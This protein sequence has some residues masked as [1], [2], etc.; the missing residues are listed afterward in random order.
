MSRSVM[1]TF[2][3]VIL[4]QAQSAVRAGVISG[5]LADS[6]YDHKNIF[7]RLEKDRIDSRIKIRENASPKSRGSPYRAE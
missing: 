6:V 7:N 4:D 3:P 2:F 5:V 1:G